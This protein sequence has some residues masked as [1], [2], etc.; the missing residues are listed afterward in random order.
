MSQRP[1]QQAVKLPP[2]LEPLQG[3]K[4]VGVKVE[5]SNRLSVEVNDR[6]ILVNVANE[7]KGKGFDHVKS[8]TGIDFPET[9]TIQLVYHVSSYS[10]P[11][12]AKVILSLKVSVSYD[13]PEVE[14]LYRVWPSV[15]TPE[16]ETYEDL[17]V[18][19]R[20]HPDLRR[21]FLPED[22]EG[23]YPLRKDFKVKTEGLFVD[24]RA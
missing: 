23:V 14:S 21:I 11:E 20:G 13:E 2:F 24:K 6:S 12:L 16:R 8:I 10:D 1:P 17:G 5:S 22:F 18:I 9:R 19:F 7:L 15:W 3:M 4:G